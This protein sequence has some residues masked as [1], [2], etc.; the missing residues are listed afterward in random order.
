RGL[1]SAG[2]HLVLTAAERRWVFRAARPAGR[3]YRL[4]VFFSAKEAAF[5]A[6]SAL[7]PAGT[8]PTTLLGIAARP[9]PD[10]FRAWPR[11][12]PDGHLDVAVR[13]AG[14]GVFSWTSVQVD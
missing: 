6:F 12:R 8:A 10:G 1:P 13:R 4:L 9:L 3:A 5:K 11:D 2:A 7:L 14:P